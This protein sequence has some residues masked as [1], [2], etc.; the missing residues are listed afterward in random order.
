MRGGIP[1]VRVLK[2]L[3]VRR[4]IGSGGGALAAATAVVDGSTVSYEGRGAG[5]R[6]VGE[7]ISRP[8]G[9]G[10][11]G[12][13]PGGPVARDPSL[14][15]GGPDDVAAAIILAVATGFREIGSG[16]L[17]RAGARLPVV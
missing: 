15:R 16:R 2:A 11:P 13:S 5:F 1:D 4:L 17:G 12:P 3:R 14:P 10:P 6:D 7:D 8:L 9:C